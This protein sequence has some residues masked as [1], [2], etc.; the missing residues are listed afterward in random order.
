MTRFIVVI[1]VAWLA[2]AP[3]AAEKPP[4]VY[5]YCVNAKPK[6]DFVP[7]YEVQSSRISTV[8]LHVLGTPR[9]GSDLQTRWKAKSTG[10][11]IDFSFSE[12]SKGVQISGAMTL[13]PA[14]LARHFMLKWSTA[15]HA[16]AAVFNNEPGQAD[17]VI[18]DPEGKGVT[19]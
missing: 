5:Y 3:V 17:C 15:Y 10:N 13:A 12:F 9:L 2:A 8:S 19:P 7:S 6:S 16:G 18:Q 14:G 11:T 1:L 4:S